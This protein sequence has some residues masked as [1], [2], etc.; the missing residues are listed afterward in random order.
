[1]RAGPWIYALALPLC[2]NE[3]LLKPLFPETHELLNDWYTFNHYLLLTIYGFVLASTRGA[4]DWFAQWRYRS[5]IAALAIVGGGLTLIEYGVIQRDTP[6]DAIMANLFTWTSLM[7]FLGFGR[8]HLSF[9]NRLLSWARDASYPIYILH[10]TIIIIVAYFVIQQP[11]AAWSKYWIVLGATLL[12]SV[13]L[14]EFLLRRIRVL[15]VAFGI[16][17]CAH[18]AT[19]FVFARQS[20]SCADAQ[21]SRL[22]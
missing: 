12:I 7:A 4:W 2:L 10:Q 21:N 20:A 11:W 15:R 19:P 18:S 16:K 14:Y 17:G 1:M 9:G 6:A 5:L 3:A 22:R 8:H 13:L